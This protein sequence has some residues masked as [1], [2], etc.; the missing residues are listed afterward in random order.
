MAGLA[1]VIGLGAGLS[2]LRIVIGKF[3]VEPV[4]HQGREI[5]V[6]GHAYLFETEGNS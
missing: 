6:A 4:A 1:I 3:P 5:A 2:A